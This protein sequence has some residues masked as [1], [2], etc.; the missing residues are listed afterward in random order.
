MPPAV[1]L[2]NFISYGILWRIFFAK[3]GY[4]AGFFYLSFAGR[5][6]EGDFIFLGCQTAYKGAMDGARGGEYYISKSLWSPGKI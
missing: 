3:L 5:N 4:F 2:L 6:R 1:A